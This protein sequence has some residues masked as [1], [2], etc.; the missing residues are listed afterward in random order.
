MLNAFPRSTN[1]ISAVSTFFI[2][3]SAISLSAN[4]TVRFRLFFLNLVVILTK[5][6]LLQKSRLQGNYPRTKR[7]GVTE[8]CDSEW[9]SEHT[10][11]CTETQTRQ[12]TIS[13][14]RSHGL[15]VRYYFCSPLLRQPLSIEFEFVG[16]LNGGAQVRPKDGKSLKELTTQLEDM[17]ANLPAK[18]PEQNATVKSLYDVWLGGLD[19]DKSSVVLHTEYHAVEKMNTA[20]NIKW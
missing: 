15:S 5:F 7:A 3:F 20:L 8:V 2:V 14:R 6:I 13:L 16:C 17:Y 9:L 4:I 1:S 11:L 18:S 12:I 19:S 10:E